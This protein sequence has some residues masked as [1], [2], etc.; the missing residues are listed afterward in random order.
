MNACSPPGDGSFVSFVELVR[1]RAAAH[2]ARHA[3]TFLMDGEGMEVHWTYLQL[4]EEAR[5]IAARL[6]RLN[7]T[8]QRALLLLPPGLEFA[9]ALLGCFYAGVVAVPTHLPRPNRSLDL[10]EAIVANANPTLA[11]TT[12]ELLPALATRFQDRPALRGLSWLAMGE[13][14]REE[15]ENWAAPDVGSEDLACL[16]YTSGSTATPKGVM[17]THGN[18][19]DNS[20]QIHTAFRHDES[21]VGVIWLPPYHDMGLIGG[22]L[23]PLYG[24]FPTILMSPMHVI[25]RPLR[26]LRAISRYRATTSGGPNFI[27]DL[28]VNKIDADQCAALDLSSWDVAF[29]GAEPVRAETL[30]RFVERFAPC[31]FRE[32]AFFPCYG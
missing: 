22:V 16:Q 30:A 29:S 23:Q 8:G 4:D 18:L 15:A 2:P 10:L 20:A 17:L 25:Q 12:G 7:R 26:W 1:H 11:L 13:I 21:S 24:G 3:L 31:G 5:A 9:S 32:E 14:G 28:C 27:Y 19:I 6:Q